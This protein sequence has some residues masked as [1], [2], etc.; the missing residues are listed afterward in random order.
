[1]N[2]WDTKVLKILFTVSLKHMNSN[3]TYSHVQDLY[4]ENHTTLLRK[5][6]EELNECKGTPHSWTRRLNNVMT[7]V[8]PKGIY[9]FNAIKMP[10]GFIDKHGKLIIKI[11]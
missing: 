1:M 3:L 8:L 4:L 9:K 10:V 2:N 5:T 6:Q 11:I 7:S